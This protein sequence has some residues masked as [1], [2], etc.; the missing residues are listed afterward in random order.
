[1]QAHEVYS[2]SQCTG[3]ELISG[4]GAEEF[5]PEQLQSG[6]FKEKNYKEKGRLGSDSCHK[7]WGG[8][9]AI[10]GSAEGYRLS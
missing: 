4:A 7:E 5:D 2:G 9:V 10:H 3:V 8:W 6:V 1:M